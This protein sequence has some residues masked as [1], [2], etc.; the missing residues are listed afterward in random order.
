MDNHNNVPVVD[1]I[2]ESSCADS[3][4]ET[5]SCS[6]ASSTVDGGKTSYS[7]RKMKKRKKSLWVS[8]HFVTLDA[9][10]PKSHLVCTIPVSL[11]NA[12]MCNKM[13]NHNNVPLVDLIAE[14]SYA[15]SD[16]ETPSCSFAP[17]TVDDG[18][19]S[20]SGRKTKKRK[21]SFIEF[22]DKLNCLTAL[23]WRQVKFVK[24]FLQPAYEL[25]TTA[26]GSK[27]ATIGMLT[28][29]FESLDSHCKDTMIGCL[30]TG[31]ITPLAA[32][33]MLNKL[34]KYEDN[35]NNQ[36]AKLAVI[37]DPA[38]PNYHDDLISLK[39]LVQ[40]KLAT[41]YGYGNFPDSSAEQ[42][43]S[44]PL[45]LLEKARRK[46]ASCV[47]NGGAR[48]P[49][50]TQDEIDVFFDVTQKAYDLYADP[51]EWWRGTGTKRFPHIAL[52]ARDTLTCKGSL[53]SS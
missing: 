51:I 16:D 49:T 44:R 13:D 53:V 43:A 38:T 31:F 14:S 33:A 45:T 15:D 37:L 29:I 42:E 39:D 18:K 35:L 19:T 20:C 21:K 7:G 11:S 28:L 8:D 32:E 17:S 40:S 6:F 27:Y 5:P 3:D 36:L 41:D 34:N 46:R 24:D 23:K 50:S 25:N 2:A 9:K 4:D 48:D 52:L 1:L 10:T 26:S 12:K 30:P 22:S 47:T